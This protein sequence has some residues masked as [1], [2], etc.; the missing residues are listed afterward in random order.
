MGFSVGDEVRD[1]LVGRG[2][3]LEKDLQ[4]LFAD[5]AKAALSRLFVVTVFVT[6]QVRARLTANC[7]TEDTLFVHSH[8]RGG[9]HNGVG[10]RAF[11]LLLDIHVTLIWC[12]YYVVPVFF[13]RGNAFL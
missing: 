3:L 8:A 7:F 5:V 10:C 1:L 9:L 11:L 6:I 12:T 13:R 2:V 4:D